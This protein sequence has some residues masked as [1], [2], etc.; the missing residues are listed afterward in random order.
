MMGDFEG[1][2]KEREDFG[3]GKVSFGRKEAEESC[4]G[5][6]FGSGRRD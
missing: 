4:K 3:G 1:G 6:G 2:R 5:T